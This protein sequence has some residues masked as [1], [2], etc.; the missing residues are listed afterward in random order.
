MVIHK[1]TSQSRQTFS[2][3]Y[4]VGGQDWGRAREQEGKEGAC[5]SLAS[6]ERKEGNIWK[7]MEGV[8][9]DW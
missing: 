3:T 6:T 1:G 8:T 2:Q 9:S 4:E 7:E 5:H